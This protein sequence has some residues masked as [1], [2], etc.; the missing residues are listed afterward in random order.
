MSGVRRGCVMAIHRCVSGEK[1]RRTSERQR[2]EE[3]K[4]GLNVGLMKAKQTILQCTRTGSAAD[5]AGRSAVAVG[6]SSGI[7]ALLM[8]PWGAHATVG[9]RGRGW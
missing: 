8:A 2:E 7:C 5:A 9:S 3:R 6:T 1:R 4:K